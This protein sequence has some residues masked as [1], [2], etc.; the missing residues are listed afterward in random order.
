MVKCMFKF[1]PVFSFEQLLLISAAL[2][3]YYSE[4]SA[5]LDARWLARQIRQYLHSDRV[6]FESEFAKDISL[7]VSLESSNGGDDN[8]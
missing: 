6:K 7:A 1:I 2:E 5:S 4:G 8:A 3:A